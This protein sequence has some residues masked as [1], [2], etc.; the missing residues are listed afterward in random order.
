MNLDEKADRRVL[1]IWNQSGD[2]VSL[3]ELLSLKPLKR[4][5]ELQLTADDLISELGNSNN[6]GIAIDLFNTAMIEGNIEG[7]NLAAL[8]LD[9]ENNLPIEINR[10]LRKWQGHPI[11]VTPTD[12]PIREI[13]KKLKDTPKNAL[14]WIDL[15]RLYTI[16]GMT[17]QATKAMVT[18]LQLSKNHRWATRMGARYFVHIGEIDRAHKII[19]NNPSSSVDPWL[20]ATE[21]SIAQIEQAAPRMWSAAKR[22]L[23]K[24]FT[25]RNIAELTSSIAT[26]E[27]QSGAVKKAKS[28]FQQSLIE[29]NKTTLA[30]AKW[31]ERN[32][33][34]KLIG[35]EISHRKDAYEAQ[36]WTEYRHMNMKRALQYSCSWLEE[37]PYSSKA[38]ICVAVTAAALD[39]YTTLENASKIGLRANRN[40][41]TFR[42][43]QIYAQLALL[44][45]EKEQT[46]DT[47]KIEEELKSYIS[48]D[49]HYG[50]HS[51]ANLGLLFYRK[52][53]LIRGHQHY[54]MAEEK[55]NRINQTASAFMALLNHAREAIIVDSPAC[56]PLLHKIGE[57]LKKSGAHNN[58]SSNYYAGKINRVFKSRENWFKVLTHNIDDESAPETEE[59][60]PARISPR[61]EFDAIKPTI[62][63]PP[64]FNPKK[65]AP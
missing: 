31:A 51:D 34:F 6:V 63:L 8:V 14:L 21:L 16:S 50:A 37:E 28:L 25:P 48:K 26:L 4:P 46:I 27:L 19:L 53:D 15:A 35:K 13:K 55:F 18:G 33:S 54:Q 1:P 56:I 32:S 29:P 22:L 58:P 24:E 60:S 38:A 65:D 45:S 9:K 44:N 64:K 61:F 42:L 40:D 49:E 41:T 59:K 10:L 30:Q 17:E 23:N 57:M 20:A 2:A 5:T 36:F 11:D 3:P 47:H 62:W 12:N 52:G 43:N 39:D 7:L